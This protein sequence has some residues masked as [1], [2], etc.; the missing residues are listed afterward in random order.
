LGVDGGGWSK[1]RK[2]GEGSAGGLASGSSS[3]FDP[4]RYDKRKG[5]LKISW[6]LEKISFLLLVGLLEKEGEREEVWQ[7]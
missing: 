7:G 3:S 2:R 5:A 4:T 6:T 1:E